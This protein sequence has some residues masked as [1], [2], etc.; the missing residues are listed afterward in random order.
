MKGQGAHAP[1]GE[2][3]YI[4]NGK[5]TEGFAFVAYPAQYRS[6]GVMTFI[7]GSDGSVFQKDLGKDTAVA[8]K[9][10]KQFDP[11]ATWHRA[12]EAQAEALRDRETR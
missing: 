6:S 10:M 1:G 7:V 8:A 2:K 4:V 11:D 9:A 3:S 12:D 5:M